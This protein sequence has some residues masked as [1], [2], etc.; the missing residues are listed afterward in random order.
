MCRKMFRLKSN[1]ATFLNCYLLYILKDEPNIWDRVGSDNNPAPWA[2]SDPSWSERPSFPGHV[3][4]RSSSRGRTN[5][6]WFVSV[7]SVQ[8]CHICPWAAWHSGNV[9]VRN[10]RTGDHVVGSSAH[11]NWFASALVHLPE[12]HGYKPLLLT[13]NSLK[14]NPWLCMGINRPFE[15]FR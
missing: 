6:H 9:L 13:G 11:L 15:E 10:S 7:I 14:R 8:M 4:A 5:I 12:S 2:H 3:I 1:Y